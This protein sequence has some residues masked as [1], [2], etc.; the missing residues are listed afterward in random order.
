MVG[1]T[2]DVK[3]ITHAD[4]ID[5]SLYYITIT[6]DW[7]QSPLLKIQYLGAIVESL[8]PKPIDMSLYEICIA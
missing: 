2:N 6:I 4:A 1:N 3:N 7:S 5:S 8:N